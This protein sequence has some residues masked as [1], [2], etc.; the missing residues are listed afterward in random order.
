MLAPLALASA[1]RVQPRAPAQWTCLSL[2][3]LR[4]QARAKGLE[5]AVGPEG[6]VL[7]GQTLATLQEVRLALDFGPSLRPASR[8]MA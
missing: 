1:L 3:Q 4:V 6:F 8:P 5:L 7:G 2:T